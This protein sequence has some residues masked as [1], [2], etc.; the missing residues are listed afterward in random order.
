MIDLIWVTPDTEALIA[1]LARVSNPANQDNPSYEGLLRYCIKNNHVSI[2]EMASACLEIQCSRTIARQILRHR[3]FSFQEFSQRYA[4][5]AEMPLLAQARNQDPK[6]RQNSVD[7]VDELTKQDWALQQLQV[8][9]TARTVYQNAL[10]AGIAKEVARSVLPEG[11]TQ[12][13][14]YMSGTIRSWI[15]FLD[16][17]WQ[18]PGVQK[19]CRDVAQDIAII[20]Q[21]IIPTIFKAKGWEV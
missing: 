15:H 16:V 17:R 21:P 10:E 5:V 2:F 9:N 11:L 18:G 13:R 19:E 20:L 7:D 4:E 3:S 6:N 8:W 14:M 12:S 1:K